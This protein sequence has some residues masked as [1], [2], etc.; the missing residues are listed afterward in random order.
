MED[1]GAVDLP[2]FDKSD[3][4]NVKASVA[5]AALLYAQQSTQHPT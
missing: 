2:C 1:K 4:P 3:Q 5:H